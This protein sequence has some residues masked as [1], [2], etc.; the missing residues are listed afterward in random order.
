M[1]KKTP[2]PCNLLW[3]CRIVKNTENKKENGAPSSAYTRL[4]IKL[5]LCKIKHYF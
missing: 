3:W 4:C 1:S 2:K 5:D